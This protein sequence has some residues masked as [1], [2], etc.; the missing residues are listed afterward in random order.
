M[1]RRGRRGSSSSPP[2]P[3]AA[4]AASS[5]STTPLL[6]L[7]VLWALV[8]LATGLEVPID[9]RSSSIITI[10]HTSA[11]PAGPVGP[12]AT[13]HRPGGPD[14]PFS[15]T[16]NGTHFDID[17]EPKVTMKRNSGTLVVDISG[18]KA[19]SYEGMYQ[20]TASNDHGTALSHVIVIRQ[21]RSPLWSKERIDP[22]VVQ[23]GVALTLQ[24]RPPAGLP[25]PII[26]WMD[27]NFQRLPQSVRVSQALSGDLYFS[28]VVRND[29]R[30]DYI[31]YAR[32]PHTQT[33]QQKQP[34]TVK[35]LKPAPYWISGP[36]RNLVLAPRETGELKCRANGIPKP[37]IAWFVNGVPV[38]TD[39]LGDQG[40]KVEDD[41]IRFSEVQ[42]GASAVYQCNVS[43][44]YGYLLSNAFVNADKVYQVIRNSRALMDCAVFGSPVPEITWFK[45]SGSRTLDGE[46]FVIHDNGTLEI[47]TVQAEYSGEY[48]CVARNSLGKKENHVTLEVYYWRERSLHKHNP[49]HVEKQILTFSGNHSHGMLPGLLPSSIYSVNVRVFNGKGEGPPSGSHKFETPEGVPGAP[50]FL[51]TS[52]PGLDSMTLEWGPPREHNGRLTGYT[53]VYQPVNSSNEL[54]PPPRCRWP[55]TR[56]PSPCPDLKYSTRYK[57]YLSAKTAAQEAPTAPAPPPAF[58]NVSWAPGEKGLVFSWDYWG[59]ERNVYVEY[60][61]KNSEKEEGVEEEDEEEKEREVVWQREHVRNN[62]QSIELRGL[63]EGLHYRVRVAAE[64][65]D[66]Q[67]PRNAPRSWWSLC[68]DSEDQKPLKGSRTPSS[69]R[70]VKRDDSDDSLVDYGEGGEGQFNE[71]GSFIGQYS[72]KSGSRG[73]TAEGEGPESSEAPSP[74]T[75][76]MNS[77]NSFV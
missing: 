71:D 60:V 8:P 49:H 23:E 14:R 9:P 66:G 76:A 20:C 51:T 7:L 30:S 62:S 57:F 17:Q 42:S 52:D 38:E 31:C 4:A 35:V 32:F 16:R 5:P 15:W 1:E 41:T 39:S 12:G 48:T 3:P 21:S 73:D 70:T 58:W 2:P 50:S 56:R 34:I 10:N 43:N 22:I 64:G 46:P 11:G 40:R 33:I 36:P 55:P 26:F 44:E 19:E 59:P 13:R 61:V 27:N 28:N 75:T 6:A 47:H 24:C 67:P 63:K 54:A 68:R 18:E 29:T 69:G 72:G 37:S 65:A 77:L 74:I 45:G 25:P 53:L